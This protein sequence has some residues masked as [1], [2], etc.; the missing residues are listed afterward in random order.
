M[1][2]DRQRS[3]VNSNLAGEVDFRTIK[4]ET[5]FFNFILFVYGSLDVVSILLWID[6]IDGFFDME[7]NPIKDQVEFVT[8]KLKGRAVTWWNQFQ[9]IRM[10]QRKP[11]IRMW[12]RMKRLLQ[13]C[14][15]ALEEEEMENWP[16]PFTRSYR[17]N[18]IAE[19]HQ[20][21]S[22]EEK[23]TQ[24]DSSLIDIPATDN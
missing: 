8:Y 14:C 23:S 6:K 9:N 16:R 7:Y 11:P 2:Y 19:P 24:E 5:V 10:Y 12:R 15:L 17:T 18:E 20:Q 13:S 21:P 1:F 4:G 3:F 22:I